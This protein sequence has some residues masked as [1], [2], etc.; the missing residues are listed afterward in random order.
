MVRDYILNIMEN[1]WPMVLIVITILSSIRIAY[2]HVRKKEFILYKELLSLIFIVYILCLFYVVTFQDVDWSGSNFIPFKEILRYEI[3]SRLFIKNAIGN[4]L[5]FVPYG[6]FISYYLKTKKGY[7]I[8]LLA[9]I[10][11]L[12]IE[13]TQLLIGRVFDIDDILLNV[14]G[15]YVGHIIFYTLDVIEDHI[16]SMLKKPIIYNIIVLLLLVAIGAYFTFVIGL[17]V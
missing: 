8:L 14:I 17:G 9:L 2:L 4:I 5:I 10:A 3:G 16:P 15:S 6:F 1:V 13:Y 11:S 7:I 12:T